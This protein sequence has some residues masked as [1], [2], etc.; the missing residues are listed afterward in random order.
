MIRIMIVDD[1][2]RA[3]RAFKALMSQQA[4]MDVATEASNGKEAIATIVDRPPD[5]V[6]MDM[7]MPVMN[8]LETTRIIK[9]KWPHIG[10]VILTMYPEYQTE[11]L[12]AGADAFLLKGCPME[13]VTSVI[14][15][16]RERNTD[17]ETDVME[18]MA[19]SC[20]PQ[21]K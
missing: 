10:V 1:S 12:A 16:F 4:G 14:H 8:G 3:R 21:N 18:S 2:L 9:E 7:C 17:N 20:P 5:I 6:I 19:S 13:E 11:V 15:D